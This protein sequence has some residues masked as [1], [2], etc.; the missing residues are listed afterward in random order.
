MSW[1]TNAGSWVPR[2]LQNSG[3]GFTSKSSIAPEASTPRPTAASSTDT[4]SVWTNDS[5]TSWAQSGPTTGKK[6]A[7]VEVDV[8]AGL[9]KPKAEASAPVPAATASNEDA[10]D[11]RD[12][13]IEACPKL[14]QHIKSNAKFVKVCLSAST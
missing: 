10:T 8:L 14:A 13:V 5:G 1:T 3:D 11:G 12:E 2:A 6:R 4:S 7:V 9:K